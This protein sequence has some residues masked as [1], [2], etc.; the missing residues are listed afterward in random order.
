MNRLGPIDIKFPSMREL[1]IAG[2]HWID[3]WRR[4]VW[5]Q[6]SKIYI[7]T[8]LNKMGIEPETFGI[9]VRHVKYYSTRAI[10]QMK[11]RAYKDAFCR[12]KQKENFINFENLE[13]PAL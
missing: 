1:S 10:N 9:A 5:G 11:Y 12:P 8:Y 7:A 3:R 6:K 2:G 13:I 4:I